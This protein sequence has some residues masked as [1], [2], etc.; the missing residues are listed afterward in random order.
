M[1]QKLKKW[2]LEWFSENEKDGVTRHLLF[3]SYFPVMFLTRKETREFANKEYG[4][5]KT[6]KDL[7]QE[8]HGWRIPRPVKITSIEYREE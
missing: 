8:P 4:Y 5:I 7:R 2:G 3:K 1:K 6:R